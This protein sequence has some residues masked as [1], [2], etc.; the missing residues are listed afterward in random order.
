MAATSKWR[1]PRAFGDALEA[2]GAPA[3][4]RRALLLGVPMLEAAVA[5][6]LLWAPA[7]RLAAAVALA[8]LAVFTGVLGGALTHGRRPACGCFGSQG[9]RPIGSRD[10]ARNAVLAAL[11]VAVLAPGVSEV[12]AMVVLV[13]GSAVAIEGRRAPA[14]AVHAGSPGRP[15]RRRRSPRIR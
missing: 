2:L 14:W 7:E 11:A 15:A 12:S 8:L 1:R 13:A 6:G 3:P 10:V 9:G 4:L 5:I